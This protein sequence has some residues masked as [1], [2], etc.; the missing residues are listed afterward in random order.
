MAELL[1]RQAA[2]ADPLL[3]IASGSAKRKAM[4]KQKAQE[5]TDLSAR[6]TL[7]ARLASELLYNG[8]TRIAI[9]QY[10]QLREVFER[11]QVKPNPEALVELAHALATAY[12]RLGEDE[13]CTARHNPES[14]LMPI[15]GGGV[16]DQQRGSRLALRELAW[17]LERDPADL[18]ARWLLNL[19]YMT[20]GE[21]PLE[22]PKRW[23]IPPETF[24]SEAEIVRFENVASRRGVDVLG[25]SGGV[26]LD[27][28][29]GD[30]SLDLVVSDWAMR[31]QLRYFRNTGEG[32]FVESTRKAG[33]EGI[34]GGLNLVHADYDNDGDKDIFVLRGAWLGR[35]G[36]QP[37]SLLSND[38]DGT[39]TDVT[40]QAG[41]LSFHPT[42]TAAFADFDNDGW[43]DLFI[44]N[45]STPGDPH[46]CELYRNN[47]DGT[48][49]EV[50]AEVGI[51]Q[52]G[53][54]KGVVWGD[55]DN[56]GLPDLYLSQ[57]GADN[58]LLRNRGEPEDGLRFV[59][60]AADAGV[61]QPRS[62]FPCWFWDFDNDGWLDLF[63][64]PFP[65][66]G[67]DNLG[68]IAA[69]YLGLPVD[70]ETARLYRNRG[71]GTFEDVTRAAGLQ[72]AMLAMGANFG[73]LDNDGY[74]DAYIG[75]GE[76]NLHTLVPNR[77]YLN[78]RRRFHNVT[79]AGGFGHLQKG[80]GI[81]F[82]DVDS[83]GDQDIYAVM[84]GAY[85]GDVAY[86]ALFLNPG[87]SHHWLTLVLEGV[88]TN[89]AAIGARV[90]VKTRTAA[91]EREIHALVGTG[92]SFG[93]SSLQ[94]EIGLGQA[95]AIEAVEVFWPASKTRQLLRG[96]ELDRAYHVR[97][98]A[99]KAVPVARRQLPLPG[100]GGADDS[101]RHSPGPDI[102]SRR[103][104]TLR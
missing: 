81:A 30:G 12:L 2:T 95:E 4:L 29:N 48:F 104:A 57:L 35:A 40:V 20:L 103:S 9:T 16:H 59:D 68:S 50:A 92:G 46:P 98:G 25:L 80:H 6:L 66:F 65:G 63:A 86:N 91:G 83:D 54:V 5:T 41:V 73:D 100:D 61:T 19:A 56:D 1:E 23:R 89:R 51:P 96:L 90:R 27:D 84:G 39:F 7:A 78:G 62:S 38:G 88:E 18:A 44:G 87:S 34:V 93:S 102:L 26:V 94:Q 74:P 64:A 75:T 52:T 72:H 21:Y 24:G 55:Y 101:P 69:D 42:Q 11:P 53:F 82:G 3:V 47:G 43:V 85:A 10:L 15:A 31:A 13:N 70:L 28:L 17:L 45:E 97:E 37:N 36:H 33:L 49:T 76:P 32:S 58:I 14:C 60:V 22:C 77:M 8:E 79:T 71:D 99:A 67:G